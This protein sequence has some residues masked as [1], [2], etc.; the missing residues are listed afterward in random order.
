MRFAFGV[1]AL[2][3]ACGPALAEDV[4]SQPSASATTTI[5]VAPLTPQQKQ[6]LE[7]DQLLG[8]LHSAPKAADVSKLEG[9]IFAL[10]ARNDSPT[11]VVLLRESSAAIDARDFDPAEQMLSQL[12]ETYPDFAEG[13][14]RRAAL[15]YLMKRY[16]AALID[17]DHALALEPRNFGALIGKG[18][19]LRAQKKSDEAVAVL[20]E[21]LAVNPHLEI[22]RDTIKMIEK[23]SPHV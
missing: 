3:L 20:K 17:V 22:V 8:K 4:Q 9:D 23:E 5:P 21:A 7:L 10:W 19:I 6:A 1:L 2:V 18:M 13:W 11:A 15:Y 12:L 14:N 16:D